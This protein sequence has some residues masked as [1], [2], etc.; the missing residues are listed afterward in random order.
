MGLYPRDPAHRTIDATISALHGSGL[1]LEH[2][3][4]LGARPDIIPWYRPLEQAVSGF[5]FWPF[6]K[7]LTCADFGGLS[8]NAATVIIEAAKFKV[9]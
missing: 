5:H 8:H 9:R 4:D 2:F 1:V 7:R 3:E 6:R